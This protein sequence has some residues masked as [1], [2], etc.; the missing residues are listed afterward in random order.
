MAA[1]ALLALL[2]ALLFGGT[3]AA[4][5]ITARY[6]L[7]EI[8]D[9]VMT[10]EADDHGNSRIS[11]D[12]Q[13]GVITTGGI[14]YFVTTDEAGPVVVRRDDALAAMNALAREMTGA[15]ELPGS[16]PADPVMPG[17]TDGGG[18]TVA[19]RAGRRWILLSGD[20]PR[21]A[22]VMDVVL[23]DDPELAPIGRALAAL[24]TED[25]LGVGG[26]VGPGGLTGNVTPPALA[27]IRRGTILRFSGMARLESVTRA[28]IPPSAF[29]LP[30]PPMTFADFAKRLREGRSPPP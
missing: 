3:A 7:P 21:G 24:F 17:P 29:A 27:L 5:D 13:P 20:P 14:A 12:G 19:G 15:P 9:L 28:P 25:T 30:A 10:V 2:C 6:I 26:S 11:V 22:D 8:G 1:K 18:E 16:A 4:A 23:S